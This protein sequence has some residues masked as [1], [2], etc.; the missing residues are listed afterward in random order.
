MHVWSRPK[1][2]PLGLALAGIAAAGL[3]GYAGSRGSIVPLAALVAIAVIAL[4]LAD[5][6]VGVPL[7]LVAGTFD[8]FLKHVSDNP[9]NYLLKDGVLGLTLL[10]LAVWLAIDR[11]RR[12]D[13]VRW[14]G[15]I[16]W[17]CYAAFM[18]T[19]LL[20][21]AGSIAAGLGAFR[22]HTLFTILFVVGAIYFRERARLGKLTNLAIVLCS[23]VAASA[24]V[25]HAFAT[26][27]MHLTPGFMKASL[28]YTSFPSAAARA[29]GSGGDAIYRMYGTLVDPASLGICCAYGLLFAVASLARLHGFARVLA[30]AAIPLL[31]TGLMLSQARAAM[32]GLV[33]GVLVLVVL[34]ATRKATRGFAVA[35]ILLMLSAIPLGMLLTHG[36]VADRVLQSDQVAYAQRTRDESQIVVINGA[37]TNPFG[38]GLGATGA[39][40]GMRTDP[41]LAVDNVFFANLYETGWLGVALFLFVQATM[42][43]LAVRAALR[44]RDVIAQTSFAGI[45]AGQVALF[46]S[47]WFSQGAFDYAPVGQMF[48]LFAGAVARQDAWD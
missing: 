16:A 33:V 25:Q 10:G 48:W 37:L 22:A 15:T 24:I 18:T 7:L 42:F 14:R 43:V 27:W 9:V 6:A 32:G 23:I 38:H 47:C 1:P 20:H 45:A 21:P 30:I 19:Q 44:T 12:P 17:A 46:V 26:Q 28:H 5:W 4:T 8:G 13:N 29:A 11:T 31:G 2:L 40:G 34:L 39:G 35:G 3:L 36:T 41:G